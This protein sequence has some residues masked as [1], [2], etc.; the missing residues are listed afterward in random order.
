MRT[1]LVATQPI[2]PHDVF[3]FEQVQTA[4][5]RLMDEESGAIENNLLPRRSAAMAHLFMGMAFANHQCVDRQMLTPEQAAL[6]EHYGVL[7][8]PQHFRACGSAA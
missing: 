7:S 5:R 3:S 8:A 2:T 4:C 1:L 6:I